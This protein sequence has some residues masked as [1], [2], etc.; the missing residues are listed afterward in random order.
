M[1]IRSLPVAECVCG[2]GML[3][4]RDNRFIC[5]VCDYS[6]P[7]ARPWMGRGYGEHVIKVWE[8]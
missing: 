5:F 6:Y 7:Y 2:D 4:I 8:K 3:F 1:G